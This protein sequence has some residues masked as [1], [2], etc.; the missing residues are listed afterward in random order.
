MA[1]YKTKAVSTERLD[2]KEFQG[3]LFRQIDSCDRYIE[4]HTARM[5]KQYPGVV[6][7]KD[8]PEYGLFTIREL[9]T[10]AVCHR[11]YRLQ[12]SKIIIK[13]FEDSIEFYNPGGLSGDVNKNNIAKRQ[14]SRNPVIAKCL[15]KIGYIE[16]LGEGWDKILAEHKKHPLHPSMPE[17]TDDGSSMSVT[18]FSTRA[19]FGKDV[20]DELNARQRKAL[21][22]LDA[23]GKLTNA[24]YRAV[25]PGISDRQTLNDL[26]DMVRKG[27]IVRVGEKKGAY[28]TKV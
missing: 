6:E 15:A 21:L 5:S 2:Y 9:I 27:L 18:I 12:G 20:A 26:R 25:N 3:N 24:E 8:I 14:Y 11:D 1:R 7:R 4:E 23:H 19:N 28:Y 13:M 16:E 10:N 22:Y 17:I